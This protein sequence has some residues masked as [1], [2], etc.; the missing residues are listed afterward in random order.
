MPRLPLKHRIDPPDPAHAEG[1]FRGRRRDV[2]TRET[3]FGTRVIDRGGG[4]EALAVR[5]ARLLVVEGPDEGRETPIG[6]SPVVVGTDG[7]CDL[8][9]L[10]D[11]TNPVGRTAPR[12]PP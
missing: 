2:G 8:V 3:P 6:L 9:L 5:R 11:T 10:D 12:R 7:S 1:A 4:R